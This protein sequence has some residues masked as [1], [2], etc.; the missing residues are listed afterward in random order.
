MAR[1]DIKPWELAV[2]FVYLFNMALFSLSS[3]FWKDI[4]RLCAGRALSPLLHSKRHLAIGLWMYLAWWSQTTFHLNAVVIFF[5]SYAYLFNLLSALSSIE[6]QGW[7]CAAAHTEFS[8]VTSRRRR[9]RSRFCSPSVQI[10]VSHLRRQV[11]HADNSKY[12]PGSLMEVFLYLETSMYS[13][14]YH[15]R[16]TLEGH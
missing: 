3:L 8:L 5:P 4:L 7:G 9:S 12:S 6:R 1:P 15:Q 13:A 10:L 2:L 11:L 16:C 14:L